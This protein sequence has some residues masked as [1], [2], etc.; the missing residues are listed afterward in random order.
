MKI[1][2]VMFTEEKVKHH[3]KKRSKTSRVDIKRKWSK[4]IILGAFVW[5]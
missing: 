3:K 5:F 4:N 1:T 2:F